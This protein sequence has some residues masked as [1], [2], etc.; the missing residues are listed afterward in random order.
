MENALLIVIVV[1]SIMV[2]LLLVIVVAFLLKFLQIKDE[3]T[4]S[5]DETLTGKKIPKEIRRA[6]NNAKNAAKENLLGRQCVDHPELPARGMCSISNEIYCE[7][8]LTKEKDIKIARKHLALLLDYN[9]EHLYMIHNERAGADKINELMRVKKNLWKEQSIPVVTQKQFKI[10]IENDRI[11]DYTA[12]MAREED[13]DLVKKT[14]NF[15]EVNHDTIS[16]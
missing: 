7:L 9:W 4:K 2:L 11:E 8:C 14:L 3:G 5:L 10:N 6:I 12:V 15:L 16:L 1:L 13:C